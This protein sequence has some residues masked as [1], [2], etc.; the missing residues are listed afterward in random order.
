M[1]QG[2][3]AQ[4]PEFLPVREGAGRKMGVCVLSLLEPEVAVLG[5]RQHGQEVQPGVTVCVNFL[6]LLT[7]WRSLQFRV[8][9]LCRSVFTEVLKGCS[10]GRCCSV[11]LEEVSLWSSLWDSPV[12]VK[13]PQQRQMCPF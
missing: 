13:S 8:N 1:R 10:T 4:Q 11:S 5:S 2:H 3:W 12:D 9:H 6:L 7:A